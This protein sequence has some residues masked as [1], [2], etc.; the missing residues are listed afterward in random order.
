M[1]ERATRTAVKLLVGMTRL[2]PRHLRAGVAADYAP[3]LAEALADA[4]SA[5]GWPGFLLRWVHEAG[6]VMAVA[7]REHAAPQGRFALAT[8]A[9][10]LTTIAVLPMLRGPLHAGDLVVNAHDPA[11]AFTL[12]FKRGAVVA[13]TVDGVDYSGRRLVQSADSVR[14][15]D[16]A[17]RTLVVVQFE[18]PA[19]IRW[20][21]R[22]P[23]AW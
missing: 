16:A 8:A 15:V 18:A 14:V 22:E 20:A 3:I 13:A 17:G 11:G 10:V 12:T 5:G 4:R 19:T 21:P 23:R 1:S 7:V 9:L 6:D 2:W